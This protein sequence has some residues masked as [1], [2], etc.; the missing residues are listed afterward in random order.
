MRP[1]RHARSGRTQAGLVGWR[2]WPD[3]FRPL[4]QLGLERRRIQ[5]PLRRAVLLLSARRLVGN[6]ARPNPHGF[7]R[8]ADLLALSGP[9]AARQWQP[10]ARSIREQNQVVAFAY[11][12]LWRPHYH[13]WVFVTAGAAAEVTAYGVYS[14]D[15]WLVVVEGDMPDRA[16]PSLD[17]QLTALINSNPWYGWIQA[18]KAQP[19]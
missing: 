6:T 1:K 14:S 2:D 8:R 9:A 3:S 15:D 13:Q 10:R 18:A 16:P 11:Y 4:A 12:P 19:P 17:D 7:R 5:R